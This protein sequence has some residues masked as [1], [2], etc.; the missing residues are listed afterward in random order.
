MA[1]SVVINDDAVAESDESFTISL[2][3]ADGATVDGVDVVATIIDDDTPP[4]VV[5]AGANVSV[6]EGAAGTSRVAR[7]RVLFEPADVE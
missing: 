1:Q 2:T 3:G 4:S 5:S 6:V 7:V